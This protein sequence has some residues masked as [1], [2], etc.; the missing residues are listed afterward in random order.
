MKCLRG[1]GSSRESGHQ[2]DFNRTSEPHTSS[3]RIVGFAS[4]WNPSQ[5]IGGH[6]SQYCSR[7]ATHCK[8]FQSRSPVGETWFHRRS[9]N[10]SSPRT[11]KSARMS[12]KFFL[13]QTVKPQRRRQARERE[14]G[15]QASDFTFGY[16][17][18]S[19]AI[20]ARVCHW[21]R[22]LLVASWVR[23]PLHSRAQRLHRPSPQIFGRVSTTHSWRRYPSRGAVSNPSR[24]D[25]PVGTEGLPTVAL[26]QQT[27]ISS[28]IDFLTT[29]RY[30]IP[31]ARFYE[32][33]HFG[34]C[35]SHEC[36]ARAHLLRGSPSPS[37][38]REDVSRSPRP[39]RRSHG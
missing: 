38:S 3:G 35:P 15:V 13:T 30:R 20:S 14:F 28:V 5:P 33:L 34:R 4:K 19:G 10:F 27:R 24:K 36:R 23:T 11:T 9:P 17:A 22:R 29:S 37:A 16:F 1:W 2:H 26:S 21:K 39:C 6:L 25:L 12:A 8:Q 32:V 18:V 7:V 31:A